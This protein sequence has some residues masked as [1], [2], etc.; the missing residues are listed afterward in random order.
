MM[1]AG[2]TPYPPSAASALHSS[3]HYSNGPNS[4]QHGAG[5]NAQYNSGSSQYGHQGYSSSPHSSG[6]ALP[7]RAMPG[8]TYY[9]GQAQQG[10]GGMLGS[11]GG[12]YTNTNSAPHSQPPVNAQPPSLSQQVCS[13]HCTFAQGQPVF[14]CF[15]N[16]PDEAILFLRVSRLEDLEHSFIVCLGSVHIAFEAGIVSTQYLRITQFL[17]MCRCKTV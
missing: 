13:V 17:C 7:A 9:A 12:G 2:S 14:S 8:S 3:A 10:Q 4:S 5:S 6:N 11:H 1:L 16:P 15:Y